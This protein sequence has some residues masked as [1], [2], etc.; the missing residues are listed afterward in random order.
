MIWLDRI[1]KYDYSNMVNTSSPWSVRSGNHNNGAGA[2]VFYF[3]NTNGNA[4]GNGS[5][6]VVLETTK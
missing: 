4:N 3:N 5:F 1:D 2:G 6:R